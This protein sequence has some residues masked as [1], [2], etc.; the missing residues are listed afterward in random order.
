M[1]CPDL[2]QL[3]QPLEEVGTAGK[4]A[5]GALGSLFWAGA[6]VGQMNTGCLKGYVKNDVLIALLYVRSRHV[7]ILR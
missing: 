6:G 5:P 7:A 1:K 3:K 4:R 2:P